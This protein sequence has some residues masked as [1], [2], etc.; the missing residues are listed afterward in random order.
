[1]LP[2]R[3]SVARLNWLQSH[4]GALGISL[5]RTLRHP[6]DWK[7]DV[8]ASIDHSGDSDPTGAIKGAPLDARRGVDAIPGEWLE[9]IEDTGMIRELWGDIIMA[10]RM[11]LKE[12]SR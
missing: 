11:K 9:R 7:T 6:D 4:T 5:F 1:M 3:G 2:G 8:L 12:S 10:N